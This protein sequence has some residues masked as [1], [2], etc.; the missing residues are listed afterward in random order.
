MCN[1]D[2]ETRTFI[3]KL[4]RKNLII[5]APET[6]FIVSY[7]A[8]E[9]QGFVTFFFHF[10]TNF[11]KYEKIEFVYAPIC[12]QLKLH[13][14]LLG[15]LQFKSKLVLFNPIFVIFESDVPK[16][17]SFFVARLL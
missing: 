1:E 10:L 6:W 2:T 9:P 5:V 15:E 13:L 14:H 17:M 12:L 16:A 7:I 3:C 4:F 8:P 11:K